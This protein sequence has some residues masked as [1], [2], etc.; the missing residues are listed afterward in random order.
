M[1]FRNL[2]ARLDDVARRCDAVGR[3]YILDHH[4]V[5]R[6]STIDGDCHAG[7]IVDVDVDAGCTEVDT[8][9]I[10]ADQRRGSDQKIDVS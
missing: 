9:I 3:G 4:V 2:L 6:V 1:T 10:D 7:G 8:L 5:V